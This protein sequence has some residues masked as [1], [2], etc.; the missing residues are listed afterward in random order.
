MRIF[1]GD[2]WTLEELQEQVADAGRRS[3]V[4]PP[5]DSKRT[6]LETFGEVLDFPEHYGVNLDALNDS[7]HDF[8]DSISGNGNPPVTLLWQVAAPFRADRSF[9]I[10]CEILQD[11]ERYA[12]KDLAVTA[13]LL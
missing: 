13:V 7:L 10:I 6:V 12:G 4:V 3:V 1:S 2:T 9:G 5:A 11:A 8:A